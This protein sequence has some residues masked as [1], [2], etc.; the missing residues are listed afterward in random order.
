MERNDKV[1]SIFLDVA[2]TV[3]FLIVTFE[4]SVTW[5]Q[6]YWTVTLASVPYRVTGLS[7]S[8]KEAQKKEPSREFSQHLISHNRSPAASLLISCCSVLDL[9][10]RMLLT[11]KLSISS[12]V[13]IDRS[14]LYFD[15]YFFACHVC[16]KIPSHSCRFLIDFWN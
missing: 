6:F 13:S 9:Q 5:K 2:S 11:L 1:K 7:I 15:N 12:A 16:R 4:L 14:V 10:Y 8:R 3:S